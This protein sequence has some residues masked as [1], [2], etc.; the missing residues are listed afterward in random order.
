MCKRDLVNFGFGRSWLSLPQGR[1][2][3][4]RDPIHSA[5]TVSGR[6]AGQQLLPSRI[7]P[8]NSGAGF[9]VFQQCSLEFELSMLPPLNFF[10]T[11]L[12]E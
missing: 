10:V 11:C 2:S 7:P 8:W 9:C 12:P 3:S 6:A 4:E 1:E 5:D